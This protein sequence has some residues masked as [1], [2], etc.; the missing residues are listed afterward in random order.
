MYRIW[1]CYGLALVVLC[2]DQFSKWLATEYL[3]YGRPVEVLPF[4]NWTLLH[5]PGAAFSF[6]SD[7][8]GWQHWLLGGLALIVSLFIV[9]YLWRLGVSN[10]LLSFSLALVLGGAVGN[11]V[12][13]VTLGYVVDFVDVYLPGGCGFAVKW[14]PRCHW[15]AFNVAD[16][17]IFLGAIG[18]IVDTFR[19]PDGIPDETDI[20]GV[21]Q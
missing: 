13:R 9:V 11:L 7:A 4:L 16:S 19:N 18:L 5:N 1:I 12:D 8:G 21:Q 2:L 14:F 17:A 15:P 20:P 10:A 6:L 3:Q